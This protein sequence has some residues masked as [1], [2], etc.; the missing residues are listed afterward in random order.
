M[1]D[2]RDLNDQL[3]NIKQQ[4]LLR[5]EYER[6]SAANK[7]RAEMER[8]KA[9]VKIFQE[10]LRVN[11]MINSE[12]AQYWK[13]QEESRKFLLETLKYQKSIATSDAERLL[14]SQKMV[15]ASEAI[16]EAS[17]KYADAMA[18]VVK[19]NEERR[20]NIEEEAEKV[21][22]MT[23]NWKSQEQIQENINR[24][25]AERQAALKENLKNATSEEDLKRI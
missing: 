25:N 22:Q 3:R 14:I 19:S 10:Q 9:L 17:S 21:K 6:S 15:E 11:Q 1:A 16:Q 2:S 8:A 24:I 4:E 20:K 18:A 7:A 13:K 23:Q 12:Q 5:Q